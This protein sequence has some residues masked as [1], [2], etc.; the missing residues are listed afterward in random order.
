VGGYGELEA[1]APHR[2]DQDAELQVP[3][4]LA[5]SKMAYRA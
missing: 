1:L 3:A 4:G 2:L 5:Y